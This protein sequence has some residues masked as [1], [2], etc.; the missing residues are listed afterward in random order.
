MTRT[1]CN[2]FREE[3]K[4][5]LVKL[6]QG[7]RGRALLTVE[8]TPDDLDRIQQASDHDSAVSTIQRNTIRSRQIQAALERIDKGAFGICEGCEEAISA[9]RLAALPWAAY[10]IVCQEEADRSAAMPHRQI[11]DPDQMAA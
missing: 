5:S 11:G 10:C 6:A 2:I 4:M 7:D 1:E 9:K 3:L 8:A